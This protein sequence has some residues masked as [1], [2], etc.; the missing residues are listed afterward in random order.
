MKGMLQGRTEISIEAPPDVIWALLEDSET[1]LP[2][3]FPMVQTCTLA[4]GGHERV[5]AVR[6]CG[7]DFGGRKGETV[8]RCIEAVPRRRLA[9]VIEDDTFGFSRRLSDFWFS[10]ELDPRP[11][12]TVVSV[13]THYDPKGVTGRLM[14]ALVA[15]RKFRRVRELALGNLKALAEAAR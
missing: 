10:F 9:H 6:T 2:S 8:E 12:T 11:A 13:E 3:V 4:D 15:K 7:V 14:S 5:G 1:N